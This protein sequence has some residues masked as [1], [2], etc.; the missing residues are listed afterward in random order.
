MCVPSLNNPDLVLNFAKSIA[1]ALGIDFIHAIKKIKPNQPQKLKENTAYQKR[2]LDG[3]FKVE[4]SFIRH[5]KSVL[6]IDDIVNSRWTITVVGA[7][8]RKAGSGPV[9]PFVLASRGRN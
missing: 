2:N 6:L 7:L 5:N 4:E 9:F 3:I 1:E 8:L